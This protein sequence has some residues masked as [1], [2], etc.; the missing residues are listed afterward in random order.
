MT[1]TSSLEKTARELKLEPTTVQQIAQLLDA[2]FAPPFIA[3]YR[4]DQADGLSEEKIAAIRDRLA[5]SRA[6]EERKQAI[7]RS[8][9]AKGALSDEVRSQIERAGSA[10]RLDDLHLPHKTKPAT[11]AD[12]AREQG[13]GPLAEEIFSEAPTT[14]ELEKRAAD[15]VDADR[16]VPDMATAIAGAGTILAEQYSQ[17]VE[18]RQRA[19]SLVRKSGKLVCRRAE[20]VSDKKAEAYKSYLDYREPLSRVPPHRVLAVNRGEKAK[21]LLVSIESDVAAV[22]KLAGELLVPASHAHADL[23][24]GCATDAVDRLLLP[25]L[26]EEIRGWLNESAESHALDVFARNLRNLLLQPPLPSRRVLAIDPGYKNGCRLAAI[27]QSGAV[28][29]LGLVHVVAP[30]TEGKPKKTN[31]PKAAAAELAP[32]EQPVQ[33]VQGEQPAAEPATEPAANSSG[34]ASAESAVAPTVVVAGGAPGGEDASATVGESEGKLEGAVE[35]VASVPA[36]KSAP[37][38][39]S[40]P[41]AAAEI[42]AGPCPVSTARSEITRLVTEHNLDLIAIGNGKACRPTEELVASL[43]GKE[44]EGRECEYLIVSEAGASVYASSTVGRE[45]L[46]D[47][48]QSLRSAVS[49]GRRVLDPL[50]ELAKIDPASVGVG[51]YQHDVKTKPMSDALD[52]VVRSCVCQVGVD[53][54]TAGAP[55]LRYVAGLNPLTARRIVEHRATNG[56]FKN[57]EQLREVSGLND[58]SFT[59]AAGFLK[60]TDGDNRLDATWVHPESYAAARQL[61]ELA[62]VDPASLGSEEATTKLREATSARDH[63]ELASELGCGARALRQIVDALCHPG[64]DPRENHPPPVFRRDLVKFDELQPGAELRGRVLNVVD[65]GAFVDVGL[66]DSGLVHISRMS[67]GFVRDPHA[68]VSVGDQ[69]RVWVDT[70]DPKKRRVSLSMIEPGAEQPREPRRPSRR[71]GAAKAG[72][73]DSS[74]TQDARSRSRRP[75]SKKPRDG[76]RSGGKGQ[77]NKGRGAGRGAGRGGAGRGQRER[78]HTYETRSKSPP[79]PITQDM[80]EGKEAMRTFGDLLQF[81]K[82][83]ESDGERGGDGSSGKGGAEEGGGNSGGGNSGGGDQG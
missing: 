50:G 29:E 17:H 51:L 9:E 76:G 63:A 69:V 81:H 28:L 78:T 13:L 37:V 64:R 48:E 41:D 55:L 35:T 40:S 38:E 82:K 44:L 12:R 45:E 20:G 49:I 74:S 1:V 10:G 71:G 73:G 56:A 16:G 72:E 70:I 21:V 26:Y 5:Q 24:A 53:V 27:D 8:L 42:P 68:L 22:Q 18:L 47:C 7:L 58:A 52:D 14:V 59:Q 67:N 66:S 4:R 46:P 54:N 77:G 83:K 31:P 23:L 57:R 25:G 65:F 11:D 75:A 80:Q 33:P 6:L 60:I 43:L 3:R 30:K 39:K 61:L 79:K 32:P 2:G 15:F 36:E 62:G 34:E 19:R